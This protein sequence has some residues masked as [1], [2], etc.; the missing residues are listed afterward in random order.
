MLE[1]KKSVA[2][3]DVGW[4][5]AKQGEIGTGAQMADW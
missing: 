4:Q 1:V 2:E 3:P 5:M